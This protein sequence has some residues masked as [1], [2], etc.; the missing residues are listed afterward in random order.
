MA[1]RVLIVDDESLLRWSIRECLHQSGFEVIEA[2]SA[3]QARKYFP[4]KC[5][6][7]LLD[8]G[9]PDANGI[10]LIKEALE[11]DPDTRVIIMTCDDKAESAVAAMKAGAYHY[12]TKPLRLDELPL[13]A[14]RVAE[15]TRLRREARQLRELKAGRFGFEH[16]V[17]ISPAMRRV[18]E[19]LSR[20]AASPASTV[21]LTGESGTGKDL[22]AKAVHYS[23]DRRDAR[24]VNIT[25]SALPEA[26][27]ES[28]LFGHEKGAFT[29]AGNRKAGLFEQADRGTVFLDEIGEMSPVLQAKL[30][31]ALE[32]RAFRRV[33]G[34][35]DIHV[36][37]R[38]I[39][40][41]N[42]DLA[43]EVKRGRFRED[44]F[45]RLNVM[46]VEL[47]PLR[48]RVG[49][50]P[51][52]AEYFIQHFAAEFRKPPREIDRRALE[53]LTTYPWPGNV[54]EFRNAIERAVLLCD[55]EILTREDFP[56]LVT[57]SEVRGGI[58]LPPGGICLEELERGLVVQALERAN[59]N[60]TRAAKLLGLNRDQIRYRIDKFHLK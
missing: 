27:L 18:K 3:G 33:G 53:L 45:Y 8:T 60:R 50:V 2:G 40:A 46:S 15:T 16:I 48:A 55:G 54:R 14:A 43:E 58:E 32:E 52:L 1:P 4:D 47:P 20:V 49:D 9:L 7:V 35:G 22:A 37:V 28:E 44:L 41:T 25:C 13:L 38:V 11:A 36:N 12:L 19:L 39:A 59:G 56:V 31:R 42:R 6:L 51:L 34:N 29:D 17:G 30:L 10:D 26:L 21:L 57:P 24:F 23:S 5:D